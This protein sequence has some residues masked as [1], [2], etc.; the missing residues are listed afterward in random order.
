MHNSDIDADEMFTRKGQ[1]FSGGDRGILRDSFWHPRG[2]R[3]RP[4]SRLAD[5]P[6]K[7]S[8][9]I[10]LYPLLP[11]GGSG[12]RAPVVGRRSIA[13]LVRNLIDVHDTNNQFCETRLS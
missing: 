2:F 12:R 11:K 4:D 6:A 7:H 9:A 5:S 8:P 10:S 13:S 3:G 1:P